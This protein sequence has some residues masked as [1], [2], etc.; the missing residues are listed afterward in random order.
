MIFI[1]TIAARNSLFLMIKGFSALSTV[2]IIGIKGI[3]A[4]ETM[5]GV[6][7]FGFVFKLNDSFF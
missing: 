3:S 1:A 4:T 6:D 5:S 7:S 2:F